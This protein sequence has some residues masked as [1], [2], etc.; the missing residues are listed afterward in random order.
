[1]LYQREFCG[2]LIPALDGAVGFDLYL[3]ILV[4]FF[5]AICWGTA[6]RGIM[7]IR[8]TPKHRRAG[9]LLIWAMSYV[10]LLSALASPWVENGLVHAAEPT[11]QSGTAGGSEQSSGTTTQP[12][13]PCTRVQMDGLEPRNGCVETQTAPTTA[14]AVIPAAVAD[15]DP[16]VVC[17]EYFARAT[18]AGMNQYD[19]FVGPYCQAR[20]S[21][22]STIKSK[23]KILPWYLVAMGVCLIACIM[24]GKIKMGPISGGMICMAAAAAVFIMAQQEGKKNK[25]KDLPALP[26]EITAQDAAAQEQAHQDVHATMPAAID[27]ATAQGGTPHTRA[28]P[29]KRKSYDAELILAQILNAMVPSAEAGGCSAGGAGGCKGTGG[30]MDFM[31][32]I[33]AGVMLYL[34]LQ[35]KKEVKKL[36]GQLKDEINPAIVKLDKA[37]GGGQ[38]GTTTFAGGSSTGATPAATGSNSESTPVVTT[39]PSSGGANPIADSANTPVAT[40]APAAPS[41][42][43]TESTPPGE[44]SVDTGMDTFNED[45]A[46][47]TADGGAIMDRTPQVGAL[48]QQYFGISTRDFARKVVLEDSR[49][50]PLAFPYAMAEHTAPGFGDRLVTQMIQTAAARDRNRSDAQYALSLVGRGDLRGT[51]TTSLLSPAAP[52]VSVAR[53]SGILGTGQAIWRSFVKSEPKT[54][55]APNSSGSESGPAVSSLFSSVSARYRKAYETK[56]L[57]Q[58]PWSSPYNRAVASD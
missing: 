37:Q 56:E 58:L 49:Q 24:G 1:M 47:A 23:K 31:S 40:S 2:V 51:S 33:L 53:T 17:D 7:K 12:G 50:S 44:V 6:F 52:A 26:N 34:Y 19:S 48:F 27:A 32:C 4:L 46:A 54:G 55:R 14:Q 11:I 41:N 3:T 10:Y 22:M 57:E 16:Q 5:G 28:S 21:L 43:A 39:T 20:K 38:V 30:G 42:P 15:R 29:R 18:A 25:I 13:L 35:A 8:G 45:I 9:G 36:E